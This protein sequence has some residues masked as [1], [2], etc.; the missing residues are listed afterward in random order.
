[1]T[2]T[3]YLHSCLLVEEHGKRLLIDPGTFSFI[4][5]ML[6]PEEIPTPEAILITH[7][8]PDHFFPDA[9]RYYIGQGAQL[10]SNASVVTKCREQQLS[11]RALA[12]GSATDLAG[13][14][15]ETIG[16]PH[17]D[18]PI[19][20]PENVGYVING[21]FF[22]FG[23]SLQPELAGKHVEILAL[24]VAAPWLRLKDALEL[25]VALKPQMAIPVHDAFIKPFFLT[26]IYEICL[27]YLEAHNI[28]FSPLGIGES[29]NV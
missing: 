29:V 22:H 24:P 3:K 28:T 20:K 9:L 18:L 23:D 19:P 12:V 7:E 27:K 5:G 16:A 26:R 13:F 10:S 17:G 11:A 4:E 14:R 6:K 15:V 1:M 2:I 25:A 8:H 21:K